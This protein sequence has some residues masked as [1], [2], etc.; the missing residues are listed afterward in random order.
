[1]LPLL[2]SPLSERQAHL[3]NSQIGSGARFKH[4][5]LG[6]IAQYRAKL[7]DLQTKIKLYDFRSIRAALVASTPSQLAR[8]PSEAAIHGHESLK[9]VIE[10]ITAKRKTD[11]DSAKS[12]LVGQVSSIATLPQGWLNNTI[13]AATFTSTSSRSTPKSRVSIIFPTPSDM[14]NAITG[15]ATGGSIHTKAQTPTHLRQID[16]LRPMLR[17]WTQGPKRASHAQRDLIPPH[18]KTYI[19]FKH[20]PT[21]E[22]PTPDISWALVTSAN[23]STQ[24]WGTKSKDGTRAQIAS[25]E[26]GVLVWPELFDTEKLTES[27]HDD[28]KEISG[29]VDGGTSAS[30]TRMIP[31]FGKDRPDSVARIVDNGCQT[32]GQETIVGFR[33]PYDLPLTPYGTEELPWSPASKYTEADRLNRQWPPDERWIG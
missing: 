4:D 33:M 3:R 30:R 27:S 15:Y 29:R 19:C 9:T 21:T 2:S 23:L 12:H 14:R 11:T 10:H 18:I 28:G 17:H 6:Y 1:M 24:A 31:M 25:Y 13:V 8:W 22:H 32:E 7:K 5:L 20:E 16:S 26:I